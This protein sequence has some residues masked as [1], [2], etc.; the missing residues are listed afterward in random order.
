MAA[1]TCVDCRHY[2]MGNGEEVGRTLLD[3]CAKKQ[4]ALPTAAFGFEDTCCPTTSHY[5]NLAF[6]LLETIARSCNDY[7]ED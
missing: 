4:A 2:V 1:R 3:F 5:S 7:S 6:C